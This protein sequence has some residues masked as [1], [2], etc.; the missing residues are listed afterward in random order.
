M[1]L[2]LYAV[3]K[4]RIEQ[5]KGI[6]KGGEKKACNSVTW[7]EVFKNAGKALTC[8]ARHICRA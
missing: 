2:P 8:Q 6:G 5:E 4:M 1:Q 7:Q 3:N